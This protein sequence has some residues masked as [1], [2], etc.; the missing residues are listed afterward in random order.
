MLESPNGANSKE[1]GSSVVARQNYYCKVMYRA[2]FK[3][4]DFFNAD[5]AQL[6]E[7]S[8]CNRLVGSSS[9][10]IGTSFQALEFQ[11]LFLL[12]SLLNSTQK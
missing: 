3:N 1:R 2:E 12:F 4:L 10:S 9:L 6:V 8:I 11:G 5:L 7:Q